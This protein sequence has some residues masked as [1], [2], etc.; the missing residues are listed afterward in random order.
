MVSTNAII[1]FF[2]GL[3][4]A[5]IGTLVGG[6]GLITLPAMLLFQIPV[7]TGIGTNKFSSGIAALSNVI[8]IVRNKL[9]DGKVV[10]VTVLLGI[11]GGITGALVT[12]NIDEQI[13]NGIVIFLLVF[14]L[15][16]TILKKITVITAETNSVEKETVL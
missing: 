13:L 1:I 8:S 9:I 15:A 5:F 2:I 11:A 3:V 4:G 16:I 7:Q 12:T 14:A 6:G 10:A